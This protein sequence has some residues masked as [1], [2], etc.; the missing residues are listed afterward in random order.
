MKRFIKKLWKTGLILSAVLWICGMVLAI[1]RG[2][3]FLSLALIAG[4]PMLFILMFILERIIGEDCPFCKT[5]KIG[6]VSRQAHIHLGKD[7]YRDSL[8]C[9]SCGHEWVVDR[10][11]SSGAE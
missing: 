8:K 10:D 5:K 9:R 6:A 11:Y 7:I 1:Y 2:K 4:G 3:D